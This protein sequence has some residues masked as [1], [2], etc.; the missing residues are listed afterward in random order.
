MKTTKVT[1]HNFRHFQKGLGEDGQCLC[2]GQ[3]FFPRTAAMGYT[4]P[5]GKSGF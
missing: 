1:A 2:A 5:G 3:A 4:P